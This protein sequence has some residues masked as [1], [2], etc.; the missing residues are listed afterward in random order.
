MALTTDRITDPNKI[1][2]QINFK[3]PFDFRE[4]L[5][6][7]ADQKGTSLSALVADALNDKYGAQF[8]RSQAP[9]PR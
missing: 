9:A 7:T 2:V 1:P 5:Y 8:A 3:V 6:T 4:F